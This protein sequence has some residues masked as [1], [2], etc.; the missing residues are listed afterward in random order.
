MSLRPGESYH[1]H[2]DAAY[3]PYKLPYEGR[4]EGVFYQEMQ[5][6]L[7]AD[8]SALELHLT[9]MGHIFGAFVMNL[10]GMHPIRGAIQKLKIVLPSSKEREKGCSANGCCDEPTSWKI[11]SISLTG[12]QEV[13]ID[14]LK[15]DDH[16]LDLLKLIFMCAPG[17]K[18]MTLKL[19]HEHT[20]SNHVSTQAHDIFRAHPYVESSYIWR[21]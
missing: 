11:Q 15:G 17:L 8:F 12:L 2:I 5:K 6:L 18:R 3:D 13:E 1:L 16:E 14:G 21:S 7:F 19:W 9:T 10:L 4:Y 20:P